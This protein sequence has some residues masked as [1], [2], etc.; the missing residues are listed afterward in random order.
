MRISLL[1]CSRSVVASCNFSVG[2]FSSMF[3]HEG[4]TA[5][6][7]VLIYFLGLIQLARMVQCPPVK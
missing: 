1:K 3:S 2:Y 5:N 6:V 7:A 4:V